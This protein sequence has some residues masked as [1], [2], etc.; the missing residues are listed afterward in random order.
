[1]EDEASDDDFIGYPCFE[2][3]AALDPELNDTRCVH[4][5]KYLTVQCEYLDQFLGDE[6]DDGY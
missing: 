6:A 2:F 5:R 1:M 4:C 3:N